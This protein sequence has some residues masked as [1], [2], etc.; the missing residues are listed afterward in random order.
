MMNEN[1]CKE[2]LVVVV[3]ATK[4]VTR[5]LSVIHTKLGFSV[6]VL[7]DVETEIKGYV[8]DNRKI[9][10]ENMSGALDE[11]LIFVK[12]AKRDLADGRGSV[13]ASKDLF[14]ALYKLGIIG[15]NVVESDGMAAYFAQA[16]P[17]GGEVKT[18]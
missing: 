16:K 8:A 10:N 15:A 1:Q 18:A 2:L 11:V 7:L 4:N 14:Y 6:K 3:T 5:V 13:G 9:L 17:S 12:A